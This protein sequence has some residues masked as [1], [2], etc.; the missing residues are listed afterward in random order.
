MATLAYSL[1]LSHKAVVHVA[2][3][4]LPS[5]TAGHGVKAAV[6]CGVACLVGA[7][8]LHFGVERPFMVLRDRGR[9]KAVEEE[10]RLDPAV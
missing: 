10:M 6:V 7:V 9:V 4:Y 1:Y 2:E 5:L 3:T 8:V